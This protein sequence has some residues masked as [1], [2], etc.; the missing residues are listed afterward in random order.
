MPSDRAALETII[1]NES[2]LIPYT[3]VMAF[4]EAIIRA[5][6]RPQDG[7]VVSP[8]EF[9]ALPMGSVVKVGKSVFHKVTNSFF[10]WSGQEDARTP[11]EAVLAAGIPVLIHKGETP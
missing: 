2:P 6:W 10:C 3:E 11:S 7:L 1:R 5:G 9:D 8:E 4:A